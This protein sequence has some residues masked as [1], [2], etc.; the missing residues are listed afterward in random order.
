MSNGHILV[1]KTL[2]KC[3]QTKDR[4]KCLEF[5]KE[6]TSNPSTLQHV[7]RQTDAYSYMYMRLSKPVSRVPCVELICYT[8]P[9]QRFGTPSVLHLI[10]GAYCCPDSAPILNQVSRGQYCVSAVRLARSSPREAQSTT[11]IQTYQ[12]KCQTSSPTHT[13]SNP[14]SWASGS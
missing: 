7:T 4:M 3:Y 6:D 1:L 12:T 8:I 10:F 9:L 2:P 13:H 5:P 14:V 11:A